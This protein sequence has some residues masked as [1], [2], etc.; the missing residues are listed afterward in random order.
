MG[1]R[2]E[3]FRLI[4]VGCVRNAD[5]E[6]L[7]RPR[8]VSTVERLKATCFRQKE[9]PFIWEAA[10]EDVVGAGDGSAAQVA[11]KRGVI[12]ARLEIIVMMGHGL[13]ERFGII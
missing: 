4:G 5:T 6:I 9:D 7:T 13:V 12:E 3:R 11:G 2:S 1:D 10:E 8:A